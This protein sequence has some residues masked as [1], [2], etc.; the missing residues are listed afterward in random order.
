ML[1]ETLKASKR[2]IMSRKAKR[3]ARFQL[4]AGNAE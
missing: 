4:L 3:A 2:R 1:Q